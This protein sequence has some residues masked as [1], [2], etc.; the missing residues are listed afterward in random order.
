MKR[1]VLLLMF[2]FTLLFAGVVDSYGQGRLLR[3]IKEEAEKKAIEE[4]FGEEEKQQPANAGDAGPSSGRNT[5]GGGLSQT[6][7][8]VNLHIDEARTSF[9]A[10][11]YTSS[12]SSLRQA[13]W[14]V[15]LEMGQNVLKSLPQTVEGLDA[16]ESSDRVSSSGIGFVGLLIERTYYGGDDMELSVSIGS[17]SGLLGIA[18]VAAA[19]G[20]YGQSTDENNYKQI[21]FQDHGAYISYDDYDGYNLSVPFGQSSIFLLQGVNFESEAD[22]MNSANNFNIQIGRAH[23]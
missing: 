20:M 7:P 9:V 5:R 22:F 23:V 4:I 8:D 14:G 12:K 17:D 16:D 13:L 10:K 19:S 2:S 18:G 11:N 21:R 15:E 3:K 6:V 1:H